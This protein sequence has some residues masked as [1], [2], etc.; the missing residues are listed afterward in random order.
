MAYCQENGILRLFLFT[1]FK[2]DLTVERLKV[3]FYYSKHKIPFCFH[4][5]VK[6]ITSN[7]SVVYSNIV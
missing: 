5:A 6:Q 4:E 2:G 1:F 7:F 3:T